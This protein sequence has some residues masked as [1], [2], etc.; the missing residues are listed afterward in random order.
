MLSSFTAG[1]SSNGKASSTQYF[2]MM[3]ATF[4]SM[5]ARTCFTTASSSA[6]KVSASS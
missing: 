2:V 6:G 1:N 5:N 4:V 3:G